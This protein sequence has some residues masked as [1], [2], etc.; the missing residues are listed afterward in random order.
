MPCIPARTPPGSVRSPPTGCR[1]GAT[2]VAMKASTFWRT[3]TVDEAGFLE[4]LLEKLEQS[5]ASFCVIGGQA[6]NPLSTLGGR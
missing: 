1:S 5:G 2:I 6:V 3:T 4:R